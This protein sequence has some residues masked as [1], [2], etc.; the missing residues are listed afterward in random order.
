MNQKVQ[1]I[2]NSYQNF[3]NQARLGRS[4]T[5]DSKAVPQVSEKTRRVEH[6]VSGK[7]G[8]SQ[9]NVASYLYN[10]SK[11][12]QSWWILFYIIKIL[13]NIKLTVAC[14]P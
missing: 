1:E 2:S 8:M 9:G 14:Y 4:K 5:M 13:Q 12:I 10:L 7:L 6:R 11:T 3:D